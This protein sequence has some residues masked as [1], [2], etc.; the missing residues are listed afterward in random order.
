MV[1]FI[2]ARTPLP[3]VPW[4][5]ESPGFN[6]TPLS[7]YEE[8][9]RVHLPLPYVYCAGSHTF[10]GCGFNEGRE[11]FNPEE[12]ASNNLDSL[13]SSSKLAQ[14]IKEHGV[15]QIYS[16]W[17]CDEGE[18]Q[19]FERSILAET[20]TDPTFVFRERELLTILQIPG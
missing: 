1:V 16:C 2:A 7:E 18:P 10:C 11:Y 13:D 17:S 9:V 14:F 15:E 20:L 12:P 6:V 4:S 3:M 8:K 5:D 19:V